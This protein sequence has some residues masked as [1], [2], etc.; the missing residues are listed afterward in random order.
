MEFGK[1]YN[2]RPYVMHA[3]LQAAARW[4]AMPGNAD[5]ESQYERDRYAN[6]PDYRTRSKE[7]SAR[8]LAIPKNAKLALKRKKEPYAND[9]EYR[10]RVKQY[11]R[12][13]Y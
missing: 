12:E 5:I 10:E 2:K 9:P 7:R 13:R 4:R 1:E 3:K 11:N 6:D 8:W